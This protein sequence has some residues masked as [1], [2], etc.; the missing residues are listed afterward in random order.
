[1]DN[2]ILFIEYI[3]KGVMEIACI[4][5]LEVASFFV[6]KELGNHNAKNESVE[7][8]T[9]YNIMQLDASE[10]DIP[11]AKV[12]LSD[13]SIEIHTIKKA[14]SSHLYDTHCCQLEPDIQKGDFAEVSHI[15]PFVEI[16]GNRY[17]FDM[18]EHLTI[19]VMPQGHN[20]MEIL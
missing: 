1:M 4:E 7:S 15:K 9:T 14:I 10:R 19:K 20:D 2:Y 3:Y 13:V 6:N 5:T 16:Q 11:E 8:P 18:I 17:Y 12:R